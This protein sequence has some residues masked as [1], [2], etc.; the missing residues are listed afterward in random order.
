MYLWIAVDLEDQLQELRQELDRVERLICSNDPALTLPLHTSL[1]ISFEVDDKCANE[2]RS[3]VRQY[4]SAL[5]SFQIAPERVESTG[6]LTWIRMKESCELSQIHGALDLIIER[7]FGVSQ[8][9]FDR[10]FIFHTTLFAATEPHK[11]EKILNLPKLPEL[12]TVRSFII[13][14]SRSGEAGT[15]S[16]DETITI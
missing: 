16:V 7:Q 12:L 3:S 6:K 13:G 5:Q 15:Y 8:H 10:E 9:V 11:L 1:K 2:V 4:L 14:S